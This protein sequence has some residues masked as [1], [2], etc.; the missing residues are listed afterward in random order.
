M[1]VYDDVE[2]L[3]SLGRPLRL[4]LTAASR[5]AARDPQALTFDQLS[6]AARDS[7]VSRIRVPAA[8][9]HPAATVTPRQY[10][11]AQARAWR[12]RLTSRRPGRPP[13]W[14]RCGLALAA[15]EG[16]QA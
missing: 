7:V 11:L 4:L 8:L 9:R 3:D 1:T 2:R 16:R 12:Y 13:R 15:P 10:Q 14:E 6:P 5:I